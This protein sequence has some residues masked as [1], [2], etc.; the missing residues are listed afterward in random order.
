M[1]HE[2]ITQQALEAITRIGVVALLVIWCFQIVQPFIVPTVWGIIIAVAIFP[3]YRTL[4]SLVGERAK[5]AAVLMAAALLLLIV[6]P[7]VL[8]VSMLADNLQV[9]AQHLKEGTLTIPPPP[10]DVKAWPLIGVPIYTFWHLAA[11]NLSAAVAQLAPQ[12]KGIARPL[13]AAAAAV[14]LSMLEFVLAVVLAGVFLAFSEDGYRLTRSIGSR[15]AGQRGVELVNLS[16][17]TIRS[18]ARGVLGVAVIQAF[19]AGVGM[20]LVGVPFAGLWTVVALLLGVLQV[21]VALVVIPAVIYVFSTHDSLPATLF[22]IWSVI[23]IFTDNVLK[24][25]LLGRGLD[26]PMLVIFV[27]ALGGMIMSGIIGLFVGAIL[28]ALGYKVFLAW[29]DMEGT[30][31]HEHS[32]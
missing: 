31:A 19:M 1:R 9:L 18:V 8:L 21:G 27:G 25:L 2:E 11:S 30:A 29:L 16:E 7:L 12:L 26:V 22:L 4:C 5:L 15:L 3:M 6:G 24:P 13:L 23:V 28:L 14:G 10:P 17:S 32:K 20:V